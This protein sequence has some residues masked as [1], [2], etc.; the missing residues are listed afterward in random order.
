MK[1]IIG[2][3]A[4]LLPLFSSSQ[5][6]PVRPLSIGDTVPEVELNEMTN[7]KTNSAKLSDFNGDLLL[8]DY[9][10]TWC[11]G[12][13]QSLPKIDSL[14]REFKSMQVL[15]VNTKSKL[16]KDNEEKIQNTL[17]RLNQRTGSDIHLPVVYN[18]DILDALFPLKYIPQV[19]WISRNKVIAITGSEEVTGE[20]ISTVLNGGNLNVHTKKDLL[21]YDNSIP[22]F[23]NGNGG[24]SRQ[25]LFRSTITNYIEGLGVQSGYRMENNMII[26]TYNLNKSLLDLIRDAYRNLM[27]YPDNRIMIESS[28]TN[29]LPS[30]DDPRSNSYCYELVLPPSNEQQV[31]EYMQLDLQKYFGIAVRNEI[32]NLKC[33]VLQVAQDVTPSEKKEEAKDFDL[34]MD[35]KKKFIYNQPL[36]FALQLLNEYSPLPIIDESNIRTTISIDLP[37]DLTDIK[38]LQEA[39]RQSGFDLREEQR[40]IEVSVISDL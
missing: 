8:L 9:W 11:S 26:G 3:V 20:N 2:L 36:S 30:K 37:F 39:F 35:S 32:R 28:K 24:K 12:C 14:K 31:L 22:L 10:G 21:S 1:H 19:I 25:I 27:K 5:S 18:N 16:S 23:D 15:L 6:P 40:K 29:L 13:L 33:L 34:Q 17:K 38:A 7:Y 4:M